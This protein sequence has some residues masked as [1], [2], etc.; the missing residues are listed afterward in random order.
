MN[1]IKK[2]KEEI[3]IIKAFAVISIVTAH[4]K[5]VSNNN[6][7]NNIISMVYSSIGVIGVPMFFIISG[8]L[9]Y[10]NNKSLKHFFKSKIKTIIIPWLVTGTL[11]YIYIVVRKGG[12]SI[13]GYLDFILGNGSYLYFLTVLMI[14]YI[15][16]YYFKSEKFIYAIMIISIIS[17][18][19]TIHKLINI[20]GYMNFMNWCVYFEFGLLL[21]QKDRFIKA[22]IL[23][24]ENR[25]F[26]RLILSLLILLNVI[27]GKETIYWDYIGIFI[28][29]F[30]IMTILGVRI[31]NEKISNLFIKLGEYSFS[32]YLLH[33]PVAGIIVNI[34][35]R[36]DLIFLL[37]IRPLIVIGIVILFI[38]IYKKVIEKF[39]KKYLF[40]IGIR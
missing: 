36:F 31:V 4:I 22:K 2:Y 37:L 29:M 1:N 35:N 10:N 7:I 15:V 30:G 21:A 5:L 17:N 23:C 18:I 28:I 3:Y 27:W 16:F 33:M 11:V 24:E 38:R 26:I 39:N 8:L 32:I 40:L 9:F 13:I 6:L 12:A 19:L 20:N 14:L 25:L 34:T